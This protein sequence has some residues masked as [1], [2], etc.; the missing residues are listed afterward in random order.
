MALWYLVVVVDQRLLYREI[1]F[2]FLVQPDL[3]YQRG[4]FLIGYSKLATNNYDYSVIRI[5]RHK[6]RRPEHSLFPGHT[7]DVGVYFSFFVK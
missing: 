1:T 2:L 6:P 4:L 7:W 5:L 3:S